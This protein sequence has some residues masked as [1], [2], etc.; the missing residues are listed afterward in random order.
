MPA[1]SHAGSFAPVQGNK[2]N[3]LAIV[4]TPAANLRKS[5]DMAV[6]Q[7]RAVGREERGV[8]L[9]PGRSPGCSAEGARQPSAWIASW[10]WAVERT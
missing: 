2:V 4:Y 6:G 7:V 5:A 3:N 8:L 1:G 10:L 9:R